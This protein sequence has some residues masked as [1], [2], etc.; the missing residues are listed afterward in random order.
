M[1]KEEE[2]EEEADAYITDDQKEQIEMLQGELKRLKGK[3]LVDDE[4]N[5]LEKQIKELKRPK[6]PKN[7]L[8]KAWVGSIEKFIRWWN[9]E[10]LTPAEREA[11]RKRFAAATES[12]FNDNDYEDDEIPPL[13]DDSEPEYEPKPRRNTKRAVKRG[14]KQRK[15]SKPKRK[16]TG[17]REIYEEED[18]RMFFDPLG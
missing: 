6:Q 18:E 8:L 9:M 15:S 13:F 11:K 2:T 3:R 14:G 10:D 17:E 1:N 16:Q 4:I 5:N 12:L 7:K